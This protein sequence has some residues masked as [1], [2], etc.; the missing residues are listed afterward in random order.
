MKFKEECGIFGGILF[1]GNI[2]S[3]VR[4]G[5]FM[6]QHRGQENA[7][8]CCGNEQFTTHK[9]KG[10]VH[11]VLPDFVIKNIKGSTGIGHVRYSTQGS[12]D[13]LHAQ[14]YKVRYLDEDVAI[15][16]NGNVS[17]TIQM[18]KDL[19]EQGETFL[20]S[21]DTEMILK[22]V[23][24][25][26]RKPPSQWKLEDIGKI[27]VDNFTGG[28]WSLLF[29]FPGRLMGF[30]DPF[31]YRPLMFC[32]A[33]DGYFI[34]SE[35]CAF[36]H[37]N[38][39]KIIEIQPGEA[40]EITI[41]GYK[42][43]K[44]SDNT[45]SKKCVFEHIYFAKPYSNIFGRNVYET[46]VELGRKCAIENPVEADVVVPVMDSG[47]AAAIGYSEFSQIPLHMGLM[48]NHWEGRSFIQPDQKSR[49]NKVIR[50]LTPMSSVIKDKRVILVDDSIVRGTTSREIVR[51]IKKAGAKEV[52]FRISAPRLV[53]TCE[54]GVD[55]PT[56]K[57][58]IANKFEKIADINNFIESDSLGYLS[59]RTLKEVFED[60]GWCY[61]CFTR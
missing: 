7:G 37:L 47:F 22:K 55:I 59:F 5:L 27:L 13:D 33:E 42:I 29:G 9:G 3:I 6:L 38:P 43:E 24:K 34:A 17:A 16:H 51:M 53:N 12:S 20:T 23:I 8:L 57:E 40:I 52:H 28:A 25:E 18:R 48:R 41:N 46:R 56:Q 11:E 26:S 36:Q 58:L 60:T 19:E 50:K 1:D 31:G 21:S 32:E 49:Q 30:R 14:P 15:A 39:K 35:D 45:N 61:H 10:L 54:W 4:D 2:A 44:I